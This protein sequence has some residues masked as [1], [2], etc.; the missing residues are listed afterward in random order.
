MD[1]GFWWTSVHRVAE[2]QTQ[3][4]RLSSSGEL[5]NYKGFYIVASMIWKKQEWA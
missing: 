5:S 1:R 4:K 2:S 3:L